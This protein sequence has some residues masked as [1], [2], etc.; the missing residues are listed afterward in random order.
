MNTYVQ[1]QEKGAYPC[2]QMETSDRRTTPGFVP[3]GPYLFTIRNGAIQRHSG[4]PKITSNNYQHFKNYND[5]KTN[6]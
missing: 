4:H 6:F 2:C 1:Q 5:E 3:A